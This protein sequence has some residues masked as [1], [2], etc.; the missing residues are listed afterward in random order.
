MKKVTLYQKTIKYTREGKECKFK[1]LKARL[2]QDNKVLVFDT[3]FTTSTK[4]LFNKEMAKKD[5]EFPVSVEINDTPINENGERCYYIINE[6]KNGYTN[7]K[8]CIAKYEN[9][10]QENWEKSLSEKY[11]EKK[12]ETLDNIFANLKIN[13]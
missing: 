3:N 11:N 10:K 12:E 5:L 9:M 6:D 4:E 1:L 7:K 13:E 8:L 2:E